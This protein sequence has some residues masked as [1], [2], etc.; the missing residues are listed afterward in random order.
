MSTI[1]K[2]AQAT[3][4]HKLR[5]GGFTLFGLVILLA[6]AALTFLFGYTFCGDALSSAFL[7]GL[8]CTLFFD[9][10][11]LAWYTARRQSGLSSEQRATANFLSVTTIVASTLVS[12]IQ[13][14]M[15]IRLVDLS[16]WHDS[17]GLFGVALVT[18]IAAANFLGLFLFQYFHP[19]EREA[20][21]HEEQQAQAAS[22]RRALMQEVHE[23]T[24]Q[25]TND[26]LMGKIP[27]LA[28]READAITREYLA[29][30][31]SLDLLDAPAYGGG[32]AGAIPPRETE[33]SP[34]PTLT[35]PE[36]LPLDLFV[37]PPESAGLSHEA[38]AAPQP[39]APGK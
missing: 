24:M 8:M 11:A 37:S 9:L 22:H 21:L 15:S 34:T 13:V 29:A 19:D 39:D 31:N 33:D 18:G 28:A 26:V 36:P 14:M 16:A 4:T 12:V 32:A 7:G 3:T 38:P 5:A 35:N 2:V 6:N 17:I 1:P 30:Y 10:A 25:R 27:Q 20:E 23:R